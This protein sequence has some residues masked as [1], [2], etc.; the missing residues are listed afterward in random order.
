MPDLSG[1]ESYSC[2]AHARLGYLG[3]RLEV[4]A[5]RRTSGDVIMNLRLAAILMSGERFARL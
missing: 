4:L 1:A 2:E 5:S 3:Q